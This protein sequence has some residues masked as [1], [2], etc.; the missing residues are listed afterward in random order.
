MKEL[1]KNGILKNIQIGYFVITLKN[2]CFVCRKS[3]TG[4]LCFESSMNDSY[5]FVRNW[6]LNNSK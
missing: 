5:E 6:C 3:D 4:F 2:D 1:L